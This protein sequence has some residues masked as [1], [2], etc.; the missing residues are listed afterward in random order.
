MV[1]AMRASAPGKLILTGEYA[2]LDGA[3]AV[4]IAVNRRVVASVGTSIASP[5]LA[6][7]ADELAARGLPDAGRHAAEIAV[8]SA[9][10]YVGAGKLGLGSSAAVTVAATALA[11]GEPL[12][13]HL[14]LAIATAAHARAQEARGARGS[15]ADI[16]AAVHG[17]CIEFVAGRVR[18]LAWPPALVLVPFFTG[19]SA[20]TGP[21]VA[22]V[23]AARPREAVERALARIAAASTGVVGALAGHAEP[24]A[25]FAAAG[26]AFD[27]LAAATGLPLVPP[28]VVAVRGMLEPRGGTAKTTGA[29]GGDVAVAIVPA[30]SD[31]AAVRAA[32]VDAGGEVLDLAI[33]PDGVRL[34]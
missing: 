1:R 10:F 14:V 7:V 20:D 29:G 24:I 12:D 11:L 27:Q 33:D 26:H 17:G 5:F 9:A 15:G 8:D 19:A 4:V 28:C 2:V 34:E 21:L 3:P 30:L 18:G 32:I 22:Q 23:T 16:A 31:V 13:P 6:A 25:A